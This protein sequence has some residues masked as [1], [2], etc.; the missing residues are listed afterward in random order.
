[1]G[2]KKKALRDPPGPTLDTLRSFFKP[3][4]PFR[5]DE[6]RSFFYS[7]AVVQ[8]KSLTSAF[9]VDEQSSTSNVEK[10]RVLQRILGYV[11]SIVSGLMELYPAKKNIEHVDFT[12]DT[13]LKDIQ[14]EFTSKIKGSF[15][16]VMIHWQQRAVVLI[17]EAGGVNWLVGKVC[18]LVSV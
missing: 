1:M 4:L 9:A 13:F 3:A 8:L 2:R 15:S 10:I 12:L 17:M 14:T 7:A 16:E 11:V 5:F 6:D 18:L